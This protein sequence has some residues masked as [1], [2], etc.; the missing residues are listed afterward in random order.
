MR[1]K[2]G[3][4]EVGSSDEGYVFA[5]RTKSQSS[6]KI[7]EDIEII[8]CQQYLI[9]DFDDEDMGMCAGEHKGCM[10]SEIL[11]NHPDYI[12]KL[13]TSYQGKSMPRYA[14]IYIVWHQ[15]TTRESISRKHVPTR[16]R[17]RPEVV[18]KD[19]KCEGGC[20]NIT[21][22]GSNQHYQKYQCFDRGFGER[23]SSRY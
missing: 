1:S 5:A 22:Q 10:F 3:T 23:K 17:A 11:V 4:D 14:E 16:T 6:N 7:D 2:S 15:K 13:H 12:T 18:K 19:K 8:P 9:G 21:T 20:K